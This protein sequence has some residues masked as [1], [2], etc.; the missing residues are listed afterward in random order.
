MT[1]SE[2]H[3]PP[4]ERVTTAAQGKD[5]IGARVIDY[6][7]ASCGSGDIAFDAAA[8]WDVERQGFVLSSTYDHCACT[9]E[10]CQ[11]ADCETFEVDA[12]TGAPL[13]R[14]PG[15]CDRLPKAEAEA[16]WEDCRRQHLAEHLERDRERRQARIVRDLAETLA[17]ALEA[18]GT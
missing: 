12:Q 15:S 3:I 16:A 1:G 18:M 6:R 10:V 9:S 8:V 13:G 11:G 17:A 2:H 4:Q 14:A 5:Q 7:C